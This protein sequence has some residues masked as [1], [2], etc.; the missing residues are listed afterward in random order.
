MERSKF[1]AISA[2]DSKSER[3]RSVHMQMSAEK[4]SGRLKSENVMAE[5]QWRASWQVDGSQSCMLRLLFTSLVL[6][7]LEFYLHIVHANGW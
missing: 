5:I 7:I 3:T 6:N 1:A 2:A 4:R